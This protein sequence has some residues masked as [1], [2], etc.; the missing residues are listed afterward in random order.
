MK[1]YQN[2]Y[3]MDYFIFISL[4]LNYSN[5]NIIKNRKNDFQLLYY[6]KYEGKIQD[7]NNNKMINI[8]KYF[9]NKE[10]NNNLYFHIK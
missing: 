1:V 2:N 10:I 3:S 8:Y 9:Q 6:D 4:T 7:N 5:W